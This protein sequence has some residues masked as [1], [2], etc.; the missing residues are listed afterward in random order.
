ML[1]PPEPVGGPGRGGKGERKPAG[2][3]PEEIAQ[4]TPALRRLREHNKKKELKG[5]F[6]KGYDDGGGLAG[7]KIGR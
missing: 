7:L 6:G 3:T 5:G 1:P 4:E 2:R